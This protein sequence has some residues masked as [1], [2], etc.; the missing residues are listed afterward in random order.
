MTPQEKFDTGVIIT[1]LI[2]LLYVIIYL[3]GET[4]VRP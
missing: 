4:H 3:I 2:A 1:V